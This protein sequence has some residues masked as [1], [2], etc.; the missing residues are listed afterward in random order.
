MD[1]HLPPPPISPI[2]YQTFPIDEHTFQVDI[3]RPTVFHMWLLPYSS[4][5]L[6]WIITWATRYQMY[7]TRI[8]YMKSLHVQ[9]LR[10]YT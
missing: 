1:K 10:Y 2:M 4:S 9:A 3:G 6:D 7:R 5:M 8:Q